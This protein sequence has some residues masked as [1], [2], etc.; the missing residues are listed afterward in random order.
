MPR[1]P[2]PKE[3]QFKKGVSGNSGGRPKIPD[4]LKKSAKPFGSQELKYTICKYLAKD[5]SEL[6]GLLTAPG[7]PS[8]DLAIIAIIVKA[9]AHGDYGR[10]NCLLDR[11]VGKVTD[12][13]EHSTAKPTL[14]AFSNGEQ[15]LLGNSEE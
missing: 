6:H 15:L 3:H 4:E 10:L 5:K 1:K 2:P 11:V 7:T 9:I 13:I 8:L 14:I 12:K